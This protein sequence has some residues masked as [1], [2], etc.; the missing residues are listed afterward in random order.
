MRFA[1]R[2]LEIA[3]MGKIT[4]IT[5]LLASLLLASGAARAQSPT[6]LAYNTSFTVYGPAVALATTPGTFGSPR[7]SYEVAAYQDINGELEVEA[8]TKELSEIGV[9]QAGGNPIT[10]V[11]AT[12]LDSSHVVTVDIDDTGALSLR[13]WKLSAAG[14]TL[15]NGVSSAADTATPL[16]GRTPFLGIATLS[17][18]QVVTAYQDP[19]GKLIVQ[20]WTVGDSS[21]K[22]VE[23]GAPANGGGVNEIAIAALDSATVITA[24]SV[25]SMNNDLLITTWGVDSAGV[26]LQGQ[27]PQLTAVTDT[28]PAVAIAAGTVVSF[29]DH[30]PFLTFKRRAVTPILNNDEGDTI[31]V[32]YWDISS[33]GMISTPVEKPGVSTD[34]GDTGAATAACML[35]TNVPMSV[36]GDQGVGMDNA[37]S[38][39]VGWFG[40]TGESEVAAISGDSSGITSVAAAAA[41]DDLRYFDLGATTAYFVTGALTFTGNLPA[42]AANPGTFELQMWSYPVELPFSF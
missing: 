37:S 35:P 4:A 33:S 3:H 27:M 34:A 9:N 14:I 38:V 40:E 11:A 31:D 32:F 2:L 19:S 8:F 23:L 15:A 1:K 17:A 42:S 20:A 22:P 30:F 26:H 18:T 21:A 24:T 41:G 5:S 16:P 7:S 10:E 36:Y 6:Q 25:P 39:H 13:N 29:S 12:G 28:R